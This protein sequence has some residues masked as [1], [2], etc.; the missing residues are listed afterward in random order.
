MSKHKFSESEKVSIWTVDGYKCFYEGTPVHYN[1]VQIDHIVPESTSEAELSEMRSYLPKNFE[2][3][4]VENWV[5]CHQGCNGR[6]GAT[7]FQRNTLLYYLEMAGKRAA[8]VREMMRDF[9]QVRDN[10]KI[11][12]RLA[13]R[14]EHGHLTPEEVNA[15]MRGV[16]KPAQVQNDPWVI[17]FGVNFNDP[18]PVEAPKRDPEL[19]DWLIQRLRND[20]AATG[21]IFQFI[22]EDRSGETTSARCAF[23][24]FDF[25][26]IREQIDFCW[27]ILAVQKYSEVFGPVPADILDRVIVGRYNAT[28]Y[29]PSDPVGISACPACGSRE[30]ERGSFTTERDTLYIARCRQCG[31]SESS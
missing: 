11:L 2:I 23:W 18:L 16:S 9:N 8:K 12:S 6:K 22:D 30:L 15:A 19:S 1:D 10:D 5:T 17:A 25:E 3:N 4:S 20:L 13:V 27:D 29:D 21:A 26:S 24:V 7:L 28:V 14:I 31:Y